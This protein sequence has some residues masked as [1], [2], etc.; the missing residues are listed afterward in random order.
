MAQRK[1][2]GIVRRRDKN[3]RKY[4][5][6]YDTKKRTTAN[7]WAAAKLEQKE[8]KQNR[9]AAKRAA[10]EPAQPKKSFYIA[11]RVSH[12]NFTDE[13][14]QRLANDKNFKLT[15]I[16]ENGD[17][18]T[19]SQANKNLTEFNGLMRKVWKKFE[20]FINENKVKDASPDILIKQIDLVTENKVFIDLREN[21]YNF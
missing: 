21:G 20:R 9:E 3:G 16:D 19:F 8:V 5:F 2:H 17:E 13:N 7:I 1:K 18:T 10:T 14:K 6:D 11:K 4:F 12:R 15:V